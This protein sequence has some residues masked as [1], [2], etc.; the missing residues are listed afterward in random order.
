MSAKELYKKDKAVIIETIGRKMIILGAVYIIIGIIL[1]IAFFFAL[2]ASE[3]EGTENIVGIGVNS[4]VLVFMEYM[5]S[6]FVLSG[7]TPYGGMKNVGASREQ[8]KGCP[9]NLDT[10]M[11]VPIRR[12]SIL[13]YQLEVLMGIQLVISAI[14]IAMAVYVVYSGGLFST[15]M[16]M[17]IIELMLISASLFLSVYAVLFRS[18]RFNNAINVFICTI[19]IIISITM[20]SMFLA[21]IVLENNRSFEAFISA[22]PFG[23]TGMVIT[24]AIA[25][26]VPVAMYVFY[27]KYA[28]KRASEVGWYE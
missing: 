3:N 23:I 10:F 18:E 24:S 26:A 19:I 17:S 11:T 5:G 21:A 14:V 9:T 8:F 27:K 6:V 20:I 25:T 16:T 28:L 13:R 4:Q 2:F 7:T 15:V 1:C 12:S 22:V